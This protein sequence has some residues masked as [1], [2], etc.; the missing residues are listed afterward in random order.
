MIFIQIELV[1]DWLLFIINSE[2]KIIWDFS[3]YHAS[4]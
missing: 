1:I 3:G 4:K 2:Y